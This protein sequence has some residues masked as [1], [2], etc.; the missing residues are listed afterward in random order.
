MVSSS[1]SVGCLVASIPGGSLTLDSGAGGEA[2]AQVAVL[3]IV[4]AAEVEDPYLLLETWHRPTFSA[5][6]DSEEE[7]VAYW[8]RHSPSPCP[9][10]QHRRCH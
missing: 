8:H 7:A 6:A 10:E 5:L 3:S 4:V 1:S 2:W 9:L